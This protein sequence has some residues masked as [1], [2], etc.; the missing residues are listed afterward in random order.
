MCPPVSLRDSEPIVRFGRASSIASGVMC[1]WLAGIRGLAEYAS[2][3]AG[4]DGRIEMV[5]FENDNDTTGKGIDLL[6]EKLRKRVELVRD[7]A[8]LQDIFDNP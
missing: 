1:S 6:N 8:H 7:H 2:K 4:S 3:H 5:I